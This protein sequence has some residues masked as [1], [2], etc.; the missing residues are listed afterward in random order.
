MTEAIIGLCLLVVAALL[1]ILWLLQLIGSSSMYT[2]Y[3]DPSEGQMRFTIKACLVV[4]VAG[5]IT[6][7]YG[8]VK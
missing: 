1:C 5:I 3:M 2:S 7:I 4:L 6:I 8:V